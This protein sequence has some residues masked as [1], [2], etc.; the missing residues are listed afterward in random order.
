MYD[1]VAYQ[2]PAQTPAGQI[3]DGIRSNSAALE[4]LKECSTG[5]RE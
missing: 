3:F 4:G 5:I 1:K 2:I